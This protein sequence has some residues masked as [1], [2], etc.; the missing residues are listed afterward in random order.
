[1]SR[2][3]LT[4][5]ALALAGFATADA[6]GPTTLSDAKALAAR[7]KELVLLDFSTEW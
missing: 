2:I 1:M 4:S 3:L 5:A 7:E 6:S